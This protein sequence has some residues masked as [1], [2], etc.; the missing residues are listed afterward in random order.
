MVSG[1]AVEVDSSHNVRAS[2]FQVTAM[3][4][5]YKIPVNISLNVCTSTLCSG[6]W[7]FLWTSSVL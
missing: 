3:Y 7:W 2:L 6:T 5:I 1:T 4:D